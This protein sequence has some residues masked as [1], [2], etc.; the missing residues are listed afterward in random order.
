[1]PQPFSV[2]PNCAILSDSSS[3]TLR[4]HQK[5]TT[6][7]LNEVCNMN[8]TL[9]ALASQKQSQFMRETETAVQSLQF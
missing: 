9:E 6:N 5:I 2:A 1:M 4:Y 7:I 8:G 3:C